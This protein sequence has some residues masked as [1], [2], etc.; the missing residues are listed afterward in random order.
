[1]AQIEEWGTEKT[2]EVDKLKDYSN[3]SGK[4]K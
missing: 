3:V 1:M 2:G 4:K